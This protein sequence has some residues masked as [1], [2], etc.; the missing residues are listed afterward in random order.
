MQY[1]WMMREIRQFDAPA[2]I[3][4]TYDKSLEPATISHFDFGAVTHG[5]V[6]AVWPRG[7]GTPIN[8]QGTMQPAVVRE[9]A[10][11]PDDMV[12]MTCIAM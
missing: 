12:I 10:N 3:V 11:I 4:M 5:L 8:G 6:L 7:L 9:H 1:I 2:S